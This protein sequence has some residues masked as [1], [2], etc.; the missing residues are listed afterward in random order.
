MQPEDLNAEDGSFPEAEQPAVADENQPADDV[1]ETNEEEKEESPQ[2]RNWREMRQRYEELKKQND[3]LMQK[4]TH[5]EQQEAYMQQMQMM[6][7]Q[8]QN[9][10]Q[11]ETAPEYDDDDLLT[12]AQ[13][14]KLASDLARKEVEKYLKQQESQN[15]PLRMQQQ[16]PDYHD[17]VNQ[18][19]V[20]K[21][22][23]EDPETAADIEALKSD[24]IRMS[25][26]LYK[27]IK[28]RYGTS[29]QEDE[30][31]MAKKKQIDDRQKAP[32]SS[33]AVPKRSAL[34]EANAFAQ[35]LTP[36]LKE[37]LWKE[38]QESSKYR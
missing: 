13:A 30:F 18:E 17:V 2:E 31:T 19:T 25:R 15:I 5:R 34:A 35:G 27:T 1:V 8:N 21:F 14:K 22:C 20:A 6:Q 33:S 23:R 12:A 29:K 9:P 4:I 16:Y 28:T 32:I 38:M 3:E 10:P 36:E 26:L 7:Q 37:Q 24:P 11:N